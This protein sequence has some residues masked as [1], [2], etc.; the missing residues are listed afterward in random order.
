MQ[1]L[2]RLCTNMRYVVQSEQFFR[3]GEFDE[4]LSSQMLFCFVTF[5][6]AL[7]ILIFG[8]TTAP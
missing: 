1:V 4:D 3:F 6:K 5:L 8:F 2:M 7:M